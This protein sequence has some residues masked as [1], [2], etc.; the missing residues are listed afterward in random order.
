MR[1]TVRVVWMCA[2]VWVSVAPV[3]AAPGLLSV[4]KEHIVKVGLNAY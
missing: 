3:S 4:G 2:L 1:I